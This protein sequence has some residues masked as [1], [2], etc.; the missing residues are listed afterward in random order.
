[1][2]NLMVE[3]QQETTHFLLHLFFYAY[4]FNGSSEE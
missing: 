3:Y 2:D 4:T 1:M